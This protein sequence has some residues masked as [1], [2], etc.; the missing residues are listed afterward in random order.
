MCVPKWWSSR[1]HCEVC[2]YDSWRIAQFNPTRE[3]WNFE[4]GNCGMVAKSGP[5][6][7][8]AD[9]TDEQKLELV[10]PNSTFE[11]VKSAMHIVS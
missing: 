9:L 10:G 4:C 6:N 2:G 7:I 3:S 5:T 1:R 8:L 11:D